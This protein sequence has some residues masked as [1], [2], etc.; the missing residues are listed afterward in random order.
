VAK[1]A[2]LGTGIMGAPIARRLAEAGHLVRAWNR[3]AEKVPGEV[4]RA[5]SPAEAVEGA[6]VVVTML[7]DGPAVESALE[8][9]RPEP[10]AIW[11]QLST[12]GVEPCERLA[13]LADEVGLVYV[14]SPVM[15]SKPQAE[16]GELVLLAAAPGEVRERL[17]PVVEPISRK[18]V[19]LDGRCEGSK[20]KLVLNSWILV[21]VENLAETIGLARQVG[22]DE[23]R[24]F[25]GIEGMPFDMG[26]AHAKGA[27]M[28]DGD[29]PP[30]FPLRLARKDLALAAEACGDLDL[31]ALRAALAQFDAAVDRG[32]GDEDA[33][34]VARVT[35]DR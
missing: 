7:A 35:L 23:S 28:V 27:L 11:L 18:V 31:P 9:V 1:L 34:A 10:G 24:F 26:Y 2:V 29:Y 13:R 8:G 14:D 3:T 15:G 6:E 22:L 30:A 21:S 20:L 5:A 4:E 25:E 32:A 16:A 12:V 33:A 19:W 17:A